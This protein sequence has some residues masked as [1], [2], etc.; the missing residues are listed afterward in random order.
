M[1]D[2]LADPSATVSTISVS[3]ASPR[4]GPGEAARAI[5]GPG[6]AAPGR[7]LPV[8]T[9]RARLAGGGGCRAGRP[10]GAPRRPPG[11]PRTQEN[12]PSG[13]AACKTSAGCGAV[14]G[15]RPRRA[16]SPLVLGLR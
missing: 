3:L 4:A 15:D 13:A 7:D 1:P 11:L 10:R 9:G 8:T 12:V 16:S 6:T 5:S 14:V 2:I